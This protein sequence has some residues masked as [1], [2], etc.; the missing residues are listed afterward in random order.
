MI[1][2]SQKFILP[3]LKT[4]YL[5]ELFA[6]DLCFG[7]WVYSL[8]AMFLRIV[9]LEDVYLYVPLVSELITG[10]IVTFGMH[11]ISIGWRERFSV[12][13]V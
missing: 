5:W 4:R 2:L 12:T 1:Y 3:R 7:F 11:L 10:A 9:L 13:I 8:L 6:C